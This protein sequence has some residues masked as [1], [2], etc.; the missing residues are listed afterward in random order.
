MNDKRFW[1]AA[2]VLTFSFGFA[3]LSTPPV[4]A[5]PS[6]DGSQSVGDANTDGVGQTSADAEAQEGGFYGEAGSPQGQTDPADASIG[7]SV[8]NPTPQ[9]VPGVGFFSSVLGTI[10]Q[11]LKDAFSKI[12]VHFGAP[13]PEPLNQPLNIDVTPLSTPIETPTPPSLPGQ[14]PAPTIGVTP[15]EQAVIDMTPA[16]PAI[17]VAAPPAIGQPPST[18]PSSP[19][20]QPQ[21]PADPT[22]APEEEPT[23]SAPAPNPR[24]FPGFLEGLLGIPP[25]TLSGPAPTPAPGL[26]SLPGVQPGLPSL[27]GTSATPPSPNPP[28]SNPTTPETPGVPMP[29]PP[30]FGIPGNPGDGFDAC[31]YGGLCWFYPSV[32]GQREGP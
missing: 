5:E 16:V 18:P 8:N 23:P 13:P 6:A 28:T 9:S 27:P 31:V 19:A 2:L 4:F 24:G 29:T 20:P 15:E 1:F 10:A 3:F 26:P 14:G 30:D 22:S 7:I 25:G 12:G 32:F 21:T 11:S 17:D